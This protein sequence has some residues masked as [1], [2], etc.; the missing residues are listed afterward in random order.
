MTPVSGLVNAR[1]RNP[2]QDNLSLRGNGGLG[3]IAV[4]CVFVLR[5][6]LYLLSKLA[7]L[8]GLGI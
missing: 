8:S 3:I 6:A 1:P 2:Y 5:K 7:F 4:S